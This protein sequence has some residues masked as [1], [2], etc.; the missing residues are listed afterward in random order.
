[1]KEFINRGVINKLDNKGRIRENEEFM[2]DPKNHLNLLFFRSIN[3][4]HCARIH[5]DDI[6]FKQNKQS[7]GPEC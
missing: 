7:I 3:Q 1:M 6:K 4:N 5:R 2:K